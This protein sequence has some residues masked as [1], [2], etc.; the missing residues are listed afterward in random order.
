M[1]WSS[2]LRWSFVS[3]LS[4]VAADRLAVGRSCLVCACMG[5]GIGA[6]LVYRLGVLCGLAVVSWVGDSRGLLVEE[7]ATGNSCC[8]TL[9]RTETCC[10]M[11]F[12]VLKPASGHP[13]HIGNCPVD[14]REWA[15]TR[16]V[17]PGTG[18]ADRGG[19]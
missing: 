5:F 1:A 9:N 3:D 17:K 19:R 14:P 16:L 12:F 13:S 2:L 11:A 18:L 6:G 10:N 15:G 7:E 4:F 8:K